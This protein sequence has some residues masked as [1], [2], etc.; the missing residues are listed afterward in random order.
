MI[1]IRTETRTLLESGKANFSFLFPR[2]VS[3]EWDDGK[4]ELNK[5]KTVIED[6]F[7]SGNKQ[8]SALD[9][10]LEKIHRRQEAFL[11][12]MERAGLKTLRVRGKLIAPFISGL[13]SGHPNET[14]MILDRNTGSPFLPASSLKGVLRTAY[15]LNLAEKDPALVKETPKGPEIDD[16]ELRKYFGDTMN[17]GVPDKQKIGGQI[18]F[19]DAYPEK[20]PE[21]KVD[22]M[23]PHYPGYYQGDTPVFPVETDS[24]VPIK[25]LSVQEGCVFIFRCFLLPHRG[26]DPVTVMGDED[27]EALRGM[28]ATAF[29]RLGF[30]GKTA[31]GYG[32]FTAL[33]PPVK[34]P[35]AG[36]PAAAGLVKGKAYQAKLKDKN[37]KGKWR[38]AAAEFPDMVGTVNNVPE[39]K[40]AGNTIPVVFRGADAGGGQVVFDYAPE[41]EAAS[42][43]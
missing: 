38:A 25:F 16:Q 10:E 3:W 14:G 8:M 29:A 2:L 33:E 36:K 40:I 9:S 11:E 26:N 27:V 17:D 20:A 31:I 7:K 35:E 32:R 6:L 39:G 34:K 43:G 5:S 4:K 13:G 30:G 41:G 15:A 19:L 28:F 22:I 37:K 42:G 24:P 21:L 18:V 23:N 1:P 12:D